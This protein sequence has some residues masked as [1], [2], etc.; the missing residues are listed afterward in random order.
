MIQRL[1]YL[2]VNFSFSIVKTLT[3]REQLNPILSQFKPLVQLLL[4]GPTR[5]I[6]EQY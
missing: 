3:H 4:W 6:R 2:K 5:A 1:I